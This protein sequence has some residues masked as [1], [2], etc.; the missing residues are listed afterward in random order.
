MIDSTFKLLNTINSPTQRNIHT[1]MAMFF[2]ANTYNFGY[3]YQWS[4][5]DST[6]TYNVLP[7]HV[8]AHIYRKVGNYTVSLT[9]TAPAIPATKT[10][11][12]VPV[13]T[14]TSTM[15]VAVLADH[16]PVVQIDTQ[17]K[18]D[19]WKPVSNTIYLLKSGMKFI[20]NTAIDLMK[21]QSVYIGAYGDGG[22]PT[23]WIPTR[24]GA[25]ADNQV[26]F[27]QW[28]T[29]GGLVFE[30][31]LFDS[32]Y[33]TGWKNQVGVPCNGPSGWM[34]WTRGREVTIVNCE[35][36]NGMDFIQTQGGTDCVMIQDNKALNPRGITAHTLWLEGFNHVV[37]GN[38]AVGS[39]WENN[40]RMASTGVTD[41]LMA[42]N[43]SSRDNK[44]KATYTIRTAL[45][46]YFY[47]NESDGG[48][49]FGF[50]PRSID[51]KVEYCI[52]D[53]NMQYD[54]MFSIKDNIQ[55]MRLVNNVSHQI[56]GV[57]GPGLT[58]SMMVPNSIVDVV[59][60]NNTAYLTQVRTF[61]G[62]Y[63]SPFAS[64]NYMGRSNKVICDGITH[65]QNRN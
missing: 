41:F 32:Q 1:N 52:V 27:A 51:K 33:E 62:F 25:L 45:R 4:F 12:A 46:G 19:A 7:S 35:I 29:S 43:K 10:A 38:T 18:Y 26:I 56:D 20:A 2:K 60:S 17:A 58:L 8:A 42:Y 13:E 63:N 34:G 55:H 36:E 23:I 44:A 53:S 31:I 21:C 9:V 57:T 11:P 40:I 22:K 61:E 39:N 6:G 3:T 50:E 16:R 37:L 65:V 54:S 59:A 14:S 5:G 15:V 24:T 64:K 30:N 49:W 28:T 48:L 47:K